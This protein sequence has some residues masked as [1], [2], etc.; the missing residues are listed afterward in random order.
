MTITEIVQM[1]IMLLVAESITLKFASKPIKD[2]AP[3]TYTH[4]ELH[5]P[6]PPTKYW[7]NA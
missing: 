3:F 5:S 6:L 4:I 7:T 1:H 2:T